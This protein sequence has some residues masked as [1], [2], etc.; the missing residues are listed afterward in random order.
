MID[1][2][3]INKCESD[4]EYFGSLMKCQGTELLNNYKSLTEQNAEL[5]KEL[6]KLRNR[7]DV[8]ESG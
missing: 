5:H 4:L 8:L 7:L 3:L 1:Q 2:S 6:S